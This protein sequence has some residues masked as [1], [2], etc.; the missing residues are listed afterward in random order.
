MRNGGRHAVDKV[1]N[2]LIQLNLV[3]RHENVRETSTAGRNR[4]ALSRLAPVFKMWMS[5]W[6][7]SRSTRDA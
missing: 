4:D 2:H 1:Y 6:C 7:D 3:R 5:F